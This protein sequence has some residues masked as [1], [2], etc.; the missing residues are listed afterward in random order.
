MRILGFPIFL[1]AFV[2]S[3]HADVPATQPTTKPVDTPEVKVV[4]DTLLQW[5]KDE[6][7]MS[8]EQ[9]RKLYHTDNDREAVYMD[10][11]AHENWEEGK[12]EQAIRDKWGNAAAAQ[13]AHLQDGSTFED[14]QV[15]D[16]KVDDDRAVATW[17]IK[18]F[19][20]LPMIRV[21]GKWLVD[22]HAMF[23]QGLKGNPKMETDRQSTGKL[24]KSA[25]DDIEQ[26]KFDDADS[27]LADFKKKL[28]EPNEN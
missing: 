3:A 9:V 22:G 11:L 6:G 20:P 17:N 26:G 15:C 10:W 16:I 14:D 1:L 8:L 25:R 7:K 27:F 23:E 28:G 4:R 2:L 12:T 5:D 21:D 18:D 13:F 19:T 24:M